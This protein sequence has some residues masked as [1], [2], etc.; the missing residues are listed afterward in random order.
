MKSVHFGDPSTLS[1]LFR[2]ELWRGRDNVAASFRR[3]IALHNLPSAIIPIAHM[4]L[5][6]AAILGIVS[7]SVLTFGAAAALFAALTMLRVWK[8]FRSG[9]RLRV[10]SPADVGGAIAVALVYDTA[11][12]LALVA[13]SGHERR[14]RA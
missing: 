11:R 3:P 9:R 7:G 10:L 6:A 1:A 5:M 4:V 2:A 14:A 8:M 13:R 12:A